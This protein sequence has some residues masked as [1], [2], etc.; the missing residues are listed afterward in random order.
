M[1]DIKPR[2]EP[3]IFRS[4]RPHESPR[5]DLEQWISGEGEAYGYDPVDLFEKALEEIRR[6]RKEL[7]ERDA[8]AEEERLEG[9]AN[10]R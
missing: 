3:W 2:P 4:T 5:A 8:R 1:S 6:L 9:L 10:R 7:A